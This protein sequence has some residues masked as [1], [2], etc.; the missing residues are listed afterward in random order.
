[1]SG[2]FS[3]DRERRLWLWTGAVLAAIYLTLPLTGAAAAT[4]RDL[5][6]LSTV[7]WVGL[8]LVAATVAVLAWREKPRGIEIGI[9]LGIAAAYIL[10]FGRMGSIEE[11]SHLIE[12]S[13]VAAFVLEALKERRSRGRNVPYPALVAIL[14]TS[15]AG[16]IDELIQLVLP[17]RVFDFVDIGFNTLAAIMAVAASVA[18]AWV[19]RRVPSRNRKS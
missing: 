11:R 6:I 18:I 5:G 7:F 2:I 3:S 8:F 14:I 12:Y 4:L 1:M 19:R 15:I 9:W 13:T 17:D 16:V 10:L